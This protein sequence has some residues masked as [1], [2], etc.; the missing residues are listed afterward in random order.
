MLPSFAPS[1]VQQANLPYV[2]WTAAFN[3]TFVLGY[4]VV[5][6]AL[7]APPPSPP[8]PSSAETEKLNNNKSDQKSAVVVATRSS[9][10][11][12]L[13]AANKNALTVFLLVRPLSFLSSSLLPLHPFFFLSFLAPT[14]NL[15]LRFC[16]FAPRPT[17]SPASSTSRCERWIKGVGWRSRRWWA[18]VGLYT[19]LGGC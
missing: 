13:E 16:S 10:P 4:L 12:L 6:L 1:S 9:V 14:T 7:P 2:L 3:T 8:S 19:E 15:T 11:P 18:T 17:S 5:Q